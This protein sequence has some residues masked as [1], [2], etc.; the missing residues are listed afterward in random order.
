MTNPGRPH[1]V[2]A[3]RARPPRWVAAAE[4]AVVFALVA[5]YSWLLRGRGPAVALIVLLVLAS[6]WWR[7]ESPAALGFRR[8]NF[9]RC[10]RACLPVVLLAGALVLHDAPAGGAPRGVTLG[11]S[12]LVLAGYTAW[13]VVQQWALNGYFLNR[14]AEALAGVPGGRQ[15]AALLAALCFSAA[16]LPNVYLVGPTF[17]L[18]FLSTLAYLRYRNLLSLGLAHG[19]LGALL[20]LFVARSLPQGL[21]TGAG[22]ARPA[23][24]P[25]R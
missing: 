6:H 24:A 19:V 23:P 16:H 2:P 25:A 7:R 12:L 5:V 1:P 22:A 11:G 21:R 9:W 4:P 18:G 13:G 10:T 3:S 20:V 17:V 14:F 8:E 15:L